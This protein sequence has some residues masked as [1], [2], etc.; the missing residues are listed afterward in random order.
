MYP[1]TP[2]N[3]DDATP[4][5]H[6]HPSTDPD[7]QLSPSAQDPSAQDQGLKPPISIRT[8]R[9]ILFTF[10]VLLALLVLT[11]AIT[12]FVLRRD[13]RANLLANQGLLD[14][15]VPVSGLSAPVTITRDA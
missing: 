4:L 10:S 6:R 12:A 11:L 2:E 13:L 7:S 14:G 8:L 1:S 9:R 3:P 5:R 15:S